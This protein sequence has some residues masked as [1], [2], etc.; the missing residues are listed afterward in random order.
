MSNL[1][2]DRIPELIVTAPFD[3][4]RGPEAARAFVIAGKSL[5]AQAAKK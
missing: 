5:R 4:S 1:D 2:G 3:T